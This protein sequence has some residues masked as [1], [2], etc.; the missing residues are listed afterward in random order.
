M[1]TPLPRA[2]QQAGLGA[3]LLVLAL[4]PPARPWLESSMS[5]H[6]L[7][8]YPV[9]MFAGLLLGPATGARLGRRLAA[10]NAHGISGLT[11]LAVALAVLMIPRVLDLALTE[12]R[13]EAA[14]VAALLLS[15]AVLR[16]SWRAAGLLVQGFFLGN[17]L[18]MTF[19]VGTLYQDSSLRLCNAYR[20]DDQQHLGLA[21]MWAAG[22]VAAIWTGGVMWRLGRG[23][24]GHA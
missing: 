17:V 3:A 2:A 24:A 10:W 21:L 11:L 13:V 14:K 9:L 5:L 6:M 1:T 20:L 15:G 8:Q 18:A 7:A 19:T 12:P 4:L 22:T 23:E 16:P